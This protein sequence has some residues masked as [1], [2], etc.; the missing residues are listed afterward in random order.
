MLSTKIRRRLMVI[1]VSVTGLALAAGSV[2]WACTVASVAA[3][4][5]VP[6]SGVRGSTFA[7]TQTGVPKGVYPVRWFD[8]NSVVAPLQARTCHHSTEIVG[9]ATNT[10]TTKTPATGTATVPLEALDG[11]AEVCT[12]GLGVQSGSASFLVTGGPGGVPLP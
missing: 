7:V 3:P 12:D 8:A 9:E 11:L 4:A 10:G 1:P 5:L 2:A 6:A